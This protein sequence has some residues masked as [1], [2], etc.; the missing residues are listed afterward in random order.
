K[1]LITPQVGALVG[2]IAEMRERILEF[3]AFTEHDRIRQIARESMSSQSN[4]FAL[5]E[6]LSD[7]SLD[8]GQEWT[9]DIEEFYS[10][11]LS[12]YYVDENAKEKLKADYDYFKEQG[13]IL[14]TP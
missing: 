2:S 8:R 13:I 14:S 4:C 12:F 5:N 9:K 10:M 11:R 6:M 1:N 3:L 7:W